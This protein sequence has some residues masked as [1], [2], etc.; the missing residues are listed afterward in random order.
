MEKT[1][2][3]DQYR[4]LINFLRETREDKGITQVQLGK[5]ID[6]N[7]DFISKVETFERRLD[8]IELRIIC[9]ALKVS[10]PKFVQD[11]ENRLNGK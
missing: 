5:L 9:S 11:F 3:N 1:I 8:V 6:E 4:R 7:Q 2:R 10:F